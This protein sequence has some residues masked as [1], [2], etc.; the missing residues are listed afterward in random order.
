ME[1]IDKFSNEMDIDSPHISP[2]KNVKNTAKNKIRESKAVKNFSDDSWQ[3]IPRSTLAE[4]KAAMGSKAK[5]LAKTTN[6]K[7][8]N[9][10]P[11]RIF[12]KSFN[13]LNIEHTPLSKRRAVQ[14]EAN[15]KNIEQL[16]QKKLKNYNA[17]E[18][19]L[20]KRSKK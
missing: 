17:I 15:Q 7:A 6:L 9:L 13:G 16:I 5:G 8:M 10:T 20:G 1:S 3:Q 4:R 18:F 12:L 19:L 11:V 2:S 14:M